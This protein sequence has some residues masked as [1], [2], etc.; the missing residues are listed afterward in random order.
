MSDCIFAIHVRGETRANFKKQIAP[1]FFS[2]QNDSD[3]VGIEPTAQ[4]D[5]GRAGHR[6]LIAD[7]IPVQLPEPVLPQPPVLHSYRVRTLWGLHR[8]CWNIHCRFPG[9]F[10][11]INGVQRDK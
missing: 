4:P 6:A 7:V 10:L 2:Q 1:F 11:V 9:N 8:D 3:L 5:P